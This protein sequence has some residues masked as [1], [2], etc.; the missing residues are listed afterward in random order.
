[1][2]SSLYIHIPFCS[3]V[4][5]Y[6]DFYSIPVNAHDKR[7]EV[8]TEKILKDTRY[9]IEKFG[10]THIF[11]V[12]IGGG[13]PSILGADLIER[14]LLGLSENWKYQKEKPEEITVEVNP[15]SLSEEFL[16]ACLQNGVNRI[17]VGIQS[18]HE[19]S[20]KAVNRAG[21]AETLTQSLFLLQ[22]FFGTSFSVDLIAGLPFQTE[23]ILLSDIE[24]VLTFKPDHISLYALTTE[25]GTS[26]D[27]KVRCGKIPLPDIDELWI[28]GRNFLEKSGY[29]QY[30]VSNFAVNKKISIHNTGYWRMENWLGI[31]SSAVS[32]IIYD[33]TGLTGEKLNG[34]RFT[35][36]PDVDAYIAG[37]PPAEEHLDNTALIKESFL[38]GFRCIEGLDGNLFRQRFD[39]SIEEVIPRTLAR[40]RG[41]GLLRPDKIA[42][43]KE[44]LLLL[45]PF[46]LDIFEEID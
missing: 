43:N 26:L 32:T 24:K 41:K 19:P 14:L 39:V 46:L 7:V 23:R 33:E 8:Y 42:L 29:E 2:R 25:E 45:N 16:M 27:E 36:E 30:E 44:G 37:K 38:M 15:E 5:D 22:N 31:G 21:S 40:W 18:F 13:T 1:M 11:S 9:Y 28:T 4:C 3:G 17:S 12:Y 34:K 6:C 35:F 10:I 20:R